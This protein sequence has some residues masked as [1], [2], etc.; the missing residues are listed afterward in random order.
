[1][2]TLWGYFLACITCRK[3]N[4]H[5]QLMDMMKFPL[6][7]VAA[8][9]KIVIIHSIM[10]LVGFFDFIGL[11]ILLGL[12]FY[13]ALSYKPLLTKVHQSPHK[14]NWADLLLSWTELTK[15]WASFVEE[16]LLDLL[17][18][19]SK[20]LWPNIWGMYFSYCLNLLRLN[21]A[22]FSINT[23]SS[24]FVSVETHIIGN[25]SYSSLI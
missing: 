23:Q 3:C 21:T 12:F 1:M 17:V 4:I 20:D 13:Q 11:P 16:K 2:L 15:T 9:S 5:L 25:S 19:R 8:I 6:F 14:W 22:G 18:E 7:T 24:W 10:F